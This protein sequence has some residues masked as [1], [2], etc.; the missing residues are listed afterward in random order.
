M[1]HC[2]CPVRPCLSVLSYDDISTTKW[3]CA[4]EVQLFHTCFCKPYTPGQSHNAVH[5]GGSN[6]TAHVACN[7]VRICCSSQNQAASPTWPVQV[8]K[9]AEVVVQTSQLITCIF[10]LWRPLWRHLHPSL[11]PRPLPRCRLCASKRQP[12]A[13]RCL[14][15]QKVAPT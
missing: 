1:A 10:T 5:A 11:A 13:S 2:H 14:L 8:Y 7:V 4:F 3:Q 9:L 15:Q 12:L 6:M